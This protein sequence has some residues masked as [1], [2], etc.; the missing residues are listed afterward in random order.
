MITGE[1]IREELNFLKGVLTETDILEESSPEKRMQDIREIM[2]THQ[3]R[4]V[5]GVLVDAFTAQAIVQVYDKLNDKNKEKL[6]NM[7]APKMADFVWKLI[8]KK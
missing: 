2:K 1:Q 7:K 8:S 6:A 3:A 5:D 4:K